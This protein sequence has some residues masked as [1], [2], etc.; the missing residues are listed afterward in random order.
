[1]E[2][3][4]LTI[5]WRRALDIFEMCAVQNM[6]ASPKVPLLL[7]TLQLKGR[8]LFQCTF[9]CMCIALC[10]VHCIVRGCAVLKLSGGGNAPDTALSGM[11]LHW[12]LSLSCCRITM[13]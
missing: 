6:C 10:F 7:Q 13:P 3:R 11:K 5:F 9:R 8:G 1:M 2:E 12:S 4:A